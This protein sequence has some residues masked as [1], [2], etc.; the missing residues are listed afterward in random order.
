MSKNDPGDL[1]PVLV[2]KNRYKIY[3][4]KMG[5]K[6]IKIDPKLTLKFMCQIEVK[7]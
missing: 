6:M 4:R 7:N 1:R 5:L 2:G 3:H